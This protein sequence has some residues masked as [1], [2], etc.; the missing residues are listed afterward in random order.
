MKQLQAEQEYVQGMERMQ[1]NADYIKRMEALG[2]KLRDRIARCPAEYWIGSR[3]VTEEE[4]EVVE[5]ELLARIWPE[6]VQ[7]ADDEETDPE[8]EGESESDSDGEYGIP[9]KY[10]KRWPFNGSN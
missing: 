4:Y 8:S 3:Q 9:S 6:P 2:E 10:R 5:R 7:A 1:E